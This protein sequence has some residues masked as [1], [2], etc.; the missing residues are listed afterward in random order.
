MESLPRIAL[1]AAMM[2]LSL[3]SYSYSNLAPTRAA[4]V[5]TGYDICVQNAGKNCDS[6]QNLLFRGN[7]PLDMDNDYQYSPDAFRNKIF[8]YLEDFR[9]VYATK[10]TLPNTIDELKNYRI[11]MVNL[12]Y[13]ATEH[14]NETEFAMLTNEFKY[15]EVARPSSVPLQHKIYNLRSPFNPDSYAFEWWPLTL[16]GDENHDGIPGAINWPLH[17]TVPVPNADQNYLP[18]DIPY[19]VTGV[20]YGDDVETEAADMRTLLA[21]QPEDG[22]PLLI[23]FHCYAGKDRTGAA[24]LS[25]YMANGGYANVSNNNHEATMTRSGPLTLQQALAALTHDNYPD[26]AEQ[27]IYAAK[28][29]CQYS[30]RPDADCT[31]AEAKCALCM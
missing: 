26:P 27:G 14:G 17:A 5:D 9:Q 28:A 24:A 21:A 29:Y 25:Y 1:F 19:L 22:H 13:D 6:N 11:V 15:S 16:L 7:F 2:M 10:A 18:M 23:F 3:S 31:L 30:G 4:L 20:A 12:L 8:S